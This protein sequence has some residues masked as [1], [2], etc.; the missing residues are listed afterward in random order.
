MSENQWKNIGKSILSSTSNKTRKEISIPTEKENIIV[1][2]TDIHDESFWTQMM[3]IAAAT[4]RIKSGMR[5]ADNNVIAIVPYGYTNLEIGVLETY[6]KEFKFELVTIKN[7]AQLISLLNRNRDRV[8]IQDLYLYTHGTPGEINFNMGGSPKITITKHSLANISEKSF[9][10]NGIIHSFACRTGMKL[11]IALL[12]KSKF[13]NDAEAK[14]D[15]SLAM[16]MAKYFH[17]QVNAFLT[18]TFYRHVLRDYQLDSKIEQELKSLRKKNGDN[19]VYNL[20]NEYEALP[21]KGISDG[22]TNFGARKAGT[23]NY[24]LWPIH[25]GRCR[26]SSASTPKGLSKGVKIFTP[27]GTWS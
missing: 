6:K 18:R 23:D 12:N 17:V 2:G 25:G 19:S 4:Y 1:I 13:N 10:V 14:P 15:E 26:P 16:Q 11:S 9:S 20:F 8:K 7:S 21:H 27:D 3:F 22:I 5:A 24:V